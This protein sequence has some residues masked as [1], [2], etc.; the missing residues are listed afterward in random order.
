MTL[1]VKPCET[2][3]M[4]QIAKFIDATVERLISSTANNNKGELAMQLNENAHARAI[5]MS[6]VAFAISLAA[7][8]AISN[9]ANAQV[10]KVHEVNPIKLMR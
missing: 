5:G 9:N 3:V 6:L 2:A 10:T 8:L 7:I 1:N 4:R